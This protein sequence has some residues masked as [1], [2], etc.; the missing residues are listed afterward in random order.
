LSL[1]DTN[2]ASVPLRGSADRLGTIA[3]ITPNVSVDRTLVVPSLKQGSVLRTDR[4]LA[5]AGGKGLNVARSLRALQHTPLA[6]GMVGG[7]T[8]ELV[9]ALTKDEGIAAQWTHIAGETRTCVVIVSQDSASA[10]VI[11]ETGPAISRDEWKAF[12]ASALHAVIEMQTVCLCGS[13]PPGVPAEAYGSLVGQ[14]VERGARVF[15]DSHGDAL[16]CAVAATPTGIKINGDEAGA[17]LARVIRTADEAADAAEELHAKGIAQVIITLGAAGAVLAHAGGTLHARPPAIRTVSAVGSGDA[18]LAGYVAALIEHADP[19][20]ALSR[21]VAAG[22]ANTRSS[23][24]GVFQREHYL[25]ALDQVSVID[26]DGGSKME[27]NA[28]VNQRKHRLGIL[29]RRSRRG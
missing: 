6:V 19:R 2:T 17:L 20:Q 1:T 4:T 21:G 26:M 15:V 25:D 16:L 18:F 27:P 7:H 23:W 12:E 22:V 11:N 9:A 10:T 29:G 28:R 5:V 8:G 13:V 14:L 24:G 3:C